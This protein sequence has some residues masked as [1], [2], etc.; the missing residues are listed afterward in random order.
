MKTYYIEQY[1]SAWKK[2]LELEREKEKVLARKALDTAYYL[3]KVLVDKYEVKRVYLFGSLALYLKGLKVFKLT[4][5]I[6]LAVEPIPKDKYFHILAEIN[7]LSE[8]EVDIIDLKDCPETLKDSIL[9]N[10]VILYEE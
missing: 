3:T 2:R 5:D 4:S 1:V 8:F 9:R 7:R 10:G 6:D